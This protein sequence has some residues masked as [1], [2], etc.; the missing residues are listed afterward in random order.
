LSPARLPPAFTLQH[1]LDLMEDD[2]SSDGTDALK[3]RLGKSSFGPLTRRVRLA[4]RL[5]WLT[6]GHC[7]TSISLDPTTISLRYPPY[8]RPFDPRQFARLATRLSSK[9]RN[10][11][12]LRTSPPPS[13]TRSS[14]K[15]RPF[16]DTV[17]SKS[18]CGPLPLRPIAT[19]NP[20]LPTAPI[21]VGQSRPIPP[22]PIR[23]QVSRNDHRQS[24][25]PRANTLR[26][27]PFFLRQ[28]LARL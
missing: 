3:L 8:S 20:S 12:S 25:R 26:V 4:S 1:T 13:S 22:R 7:S 14:A 28:T 6:S 27:H 15:K 5:T 11:S 24:R 9:R 19:L 21:R 17:T 23:S 16:S 10:R 2:W 18:K